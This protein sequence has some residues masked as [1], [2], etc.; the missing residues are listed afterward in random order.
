VEA[1]TLNLETGAEGE[2]ELS[3][4]D[5]YALPVWIKDTLYVYT[6]KVIYHVDG[7]KIV[8]LPSP[9]C[10]CLSPP[11][12]YDGH[13]TVVYNARGLNDEGYEH[14]RLGHWIDGRFVEG[15][16]IVLPQFDRFWF[17]DPQQGRKVLFPRTSVS[18][19]I[20]IWPGSRVFL[21]VSLVGDR[22]SW[23]RAFAFGDRI[24]DTVVVADREFRA[25]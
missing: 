20:R 12:L 18:N 8:Q 23:E 9:F 1:S 5:D 6:Y 2:T 16:R 4:D 15:R 22:V 17:D 10:D 14:I 7:S 21:S 19:E 13:M 24:A 25:G 3:F 11:F